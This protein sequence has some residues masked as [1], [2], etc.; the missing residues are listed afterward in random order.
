MPVRLASVYATVCR[1]YVPIP[2]LR[3]QPRVTVRSYSGASDD[4]SRICNLIL[5]M[6]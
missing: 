1:G 5:C 3:R 2:Y 6:S 4:M